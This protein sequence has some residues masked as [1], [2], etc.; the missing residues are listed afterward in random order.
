MISEMPDAPEKRQRHR[1]IVDLVS[2]NRVDSQDE[3]LD[4]LQAEGVETTQST[5]SRDLRELGI[6]KGSA[7]YRIPNRDPAGPD[8]LR[9]LSQALRRRLLSVDWGGNLVVLGT[10]G[11]DDAREVAARIERAKL[12]QVTAAVV[13][14]ERVLIV[15]RSQAY[16]RELLRRLRDRPRR[17]LLRRSD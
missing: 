7:G 8:T 13:C 5:L 10:A 6:V 2:R 12:H 1:Q 17:A 3:L 15:A 16:A 4:L 11:A 9:R 14:E